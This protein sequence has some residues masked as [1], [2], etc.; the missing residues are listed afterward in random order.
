MSPSFFS[1]GIPL[2]PVVVIAAAAAAFYALFEQ[3]R[4]RSLERVLMRERKSDSNEESER[5]K[6]E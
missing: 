6:G 5:S 4:D 3:R 1:F 2:Q